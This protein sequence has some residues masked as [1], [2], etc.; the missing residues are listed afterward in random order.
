MEVP[1][2]IK[3]MAE[4]LAGSNARIQVQIDNK[5]Y[6]QTIGDTAALSKS[7]IYYY[8]NT[9]HRDRSSFLAWMRGAIMKANIKES[10]REN[11]LCTLRLLSEFRAGFGFDDLNKKL[12]SAFRQFLVGRGYK[13]NTITKHLKVFRRYVNTAA[14][15]EMLVGNPFDHL[16][17]HYERSHKEFLTENEV[18]LLLH[19]VSTLTNSYE[20]EAVRAFLFSCYTGLR[21]SDVQRVTLR[22]V[23]TDDGVTWLT[24]RMQKTSYDV[25]IPVSEL[26]GG[27]AL[28]LLNRELGDDDR[29]FPVPD[30][31]VANNN[32]RRV[33]RRFGI[34]KHIS[35][36]CARVTCASLMLEKNIPLTTIQ[37][38]LGHASVNTTEVY[39]KM[40]ETTI[41]KSIR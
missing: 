11:H 13:T 4:A 39:A 19:K 5:C 7:P 8:L 29:Q 30:G 27:A 26:F 2:L 41:L 24:M 32:I 33:L 21:Y 25:R 37:H 1:V 3:F 6:E 16:T 10:T 20:Y 38:I 18:C 9:G 35:F 14:S 23:H 28:L 36:H 12:V 40:N 31:C 17:M 34:T 15:E 22:H